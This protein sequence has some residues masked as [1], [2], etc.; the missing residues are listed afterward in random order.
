MFK[1]TDR[2]LKIISISKIY[3]KVTISGKPFQSGGI[4]IMAVDRVSYRAIGKVQEFKNLVRWSWML[5]REGNN[6]RTRIITSY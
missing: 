5:L 1:R 6:T 2:W 4:A 3:N